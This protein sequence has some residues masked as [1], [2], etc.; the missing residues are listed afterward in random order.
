MISDEDF[1]DLSVLIAGLVAANARL[2]STQPGS[3]EAFHGAFE[4]LAWIGAIRDRLRRDRQPVPPIVNGLYYVRNVVIHQGADVL[5]W[6]IIHGSSL[7][8]WVLGKGQLG[9]RSQKYWTWPLSAE[10]PTPLYET[11]KEEYDTLVGGRDAAETLA[12]AAGSL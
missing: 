4:A 3:S 10:M 1:V 5:E 2:T 6:M 9:R 7:D 8:D 11:G 12:E